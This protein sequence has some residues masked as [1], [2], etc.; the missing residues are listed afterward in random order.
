MQVKHTGLIA[1][2]FALAVP[3]LAVTQTDI[4]TGL[5]GAIGIAAD[6]E[7]SAI[8]FVEFNTGTLKRIA[9][10]PGCTLVT[11]PPVPLAQ[12]G[13]GSRPVWGEQGAR[14]AL[15]GA[16]FARVVTL[17]PTPNRRP[18]TPGRA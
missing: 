12:G 13:P 3:A 16:G 10:T 6:P 8:Y 4:A 2:L 17:S 1:L 7:G 5:S 11:C 9:T 14:R 18:S 15:G